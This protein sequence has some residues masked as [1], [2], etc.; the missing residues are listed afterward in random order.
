MISQKR[1]D[2]AYL[3]RKPEHDGHPTNLKT[4][5]DDPLLASRVLNIDSDGRRVREVAQPAIMW[6][7]CLE[8]VEVFLY[9]GRANPH[10]QVLQVE[11]RVSQAGHS[12]VGHHNVPN[13]LVDK[14]VKARNVLLHQ[15]PH[16]ERERIPK[17]DKKTYSV[18][19]SICATFHIPFTDM[20]Q[21]FRP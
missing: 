7:G 12:L 14:I 9:V 13:V 10:V 16:L 1:A 11:H 19:Y 4:V 5:P 8:L 18:L 2:L 15:T 6:A 21:T 17:K 3:A 20:K